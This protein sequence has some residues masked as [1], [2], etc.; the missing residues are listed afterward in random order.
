VAVV[1]DPV[2]SVK[3]KVVID[4]FRSI[5]Q[6]TMMMR[7]EP[8][9][10]TSNIGHISRPSYNALS[11]GLNKHYYSIAINYRKNENEQKM[12]L[13][14]NKT[15]WANS[16]K[17]QAYT[18]QEKSNVEAIKNLEKLTNQYNKWIKEETS[19]STDEFVVSSVG[20][21]NPKNRLAQ[22]IDQNLNDNVMNCLGTMLN[23]VVF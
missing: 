13:N 18:E 21:T 14:L 16:L 10:T 3:G 8:R 9:Q 4:A 7:L 5:D 12:L 17:L 1:V 19:K 11:H 15:M 2:Q 22:E 20:K 23:T 6:Q